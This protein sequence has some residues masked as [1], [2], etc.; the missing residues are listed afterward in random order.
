MHWLL[1]THTVC[2]EKKMI[3]TKNFNTTLH[4]PIDVLYYNIFLGLLVWN[5]KVVVIV[6]MY[7]L[8]VIPMTIHTEDVFFWT[9]L[10]EI[11]FTYMSIAD[12]TACVIPTTRPPRPPR[13]LALPRP[14]CRLM[15][16]L[17]LRVWYIKANIYRSSRPFCNWRGAKMN[18]KII[19]NDIFI[20]YM[21]VRRMYIVQ[22]IN[23]IRGHFDIPK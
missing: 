1:C 12:Y 20:F 5:R 9:D 2:Q 3:S 21:Y 11:P 19:T 4:S 6:N 18:V 16:Y 14:S 13:P 22:P 17:R 8:Y 15:V 7:D 23:I 10:Y